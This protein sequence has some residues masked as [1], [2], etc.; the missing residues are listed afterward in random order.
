MARMCPRPVL[1]REPV[2][3]VV[4][5]FTH[6]GEGVVRIEGKAVFVPG[7]IPG[8]HVRVRVTDD[9][10][11]WARAQLLE[12]LDASPDRVEPPCPYVPDCGGC[13]L[14][15]IAPDAQR[16]LK[17]RVVIEQLERLGGIT[18][19]PV[20]AVRSVGPTPATAPTH[21]STP[22][23]PTPPLLRTL[24]TSTGEGPQQPGRLGFHRAGTAEV[25]PVDQCLVLTPDAQAVRDA[26]G[27]DTGAAE[28]QVR[29]HAS[30]GTRAAVLHPDPTAPLQIPDAPGVDVL[31]AQPDGTTMAMRGDGVL[32]ETVAGYA[33]SFPAAGFFQVNTGGA[34]ALVTAVLEAAGDLDG[35]LAWDLYAGVGLFSLPMAG[36]GAA[37]HAVEGHKASVAWLTS[38]AETNDLADRVTATR[39]DVRAF[40]GRQHPDP[41]DV[42]VLDP[43]RSGAG[44]R[45]CR[46][47]AELRPA[48][49]V[50]V[51]CD[52]AALA[53]DAKA[54]AASGY[55]LVDAVPLD[56]FPMTHHVEVVATFRP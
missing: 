37:V 12:V 31:L 1:S 14:Q 29:A 11:R 40:V 41:P 24:T 56:L 42:I 19:P 55:R 10:K 50:Y 30:S 45:T 54:L 7:T 32:T 17:R 34:E 35:V 18:D 16:V 25:V 9:R 28:V 4:D 39:E 43:P 21:A 47:L 53:R 38:N 3:V 2:D 23:S 20:A 22:L 52:P 5:G 8:E 48:A 6:G 36:A 26:I 44:E 33:L 51:A 46:Q 27:D 13:D 49:I 15:H